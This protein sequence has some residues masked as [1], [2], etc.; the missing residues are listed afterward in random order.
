MTINTQ[1]QTGIE[2]IS[3]Y[4]GDDLSLYK[5]SLKASTL[6]SPVESALEQVIQLHPIDRNLI[7]LTKPEIRPEWLQPNAYQNTLAQI[8]AKLKHQTSHDCLQAARVLDVC[9][10]SQQQLNLLTGLLL[11]A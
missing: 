1:F 7:N 6:G 3:D 4:S 9:H 5:T 10:Q 11:K 8:A 2:S